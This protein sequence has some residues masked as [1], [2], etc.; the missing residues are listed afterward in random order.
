MRRGTTILADR[1]GSA[2]VEMALVAPLMITLMF[3]T[4]ELGNYFMDSHVVTKAVRDG[5]R[6]AA[7]RGFPEYSC[8]SS[9]PST[10]VVTKTRNITMTGQVASGGAARLPGW[11]TA[12]TVTV[13]V[14]CDTTTLTGA[15]TGIYTGITGGA[16][17]V[18]VAADVPYNSL[19]R[20]LGFSSASLHL[21]AQAH[22][23]VTGA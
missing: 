18:T 21:K 13:V 16:P 12:T 3:G 17:T 9:T 4:F 8:G 11:T 1:S 14:T 23:A 22:A 7:R 6:Y 10:D 2:A 15:N 20:V 19:F 5:A